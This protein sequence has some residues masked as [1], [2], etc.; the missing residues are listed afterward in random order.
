MGVTSPGETFGAFDHSNVQTDHTNTGT[1]TRIPVDVPP[2]VL[3]CKNGRVTHEH[4]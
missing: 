1:S 3:T 2:L 4:I